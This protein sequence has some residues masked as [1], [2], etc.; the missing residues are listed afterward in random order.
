MEQLVEAGLSVL[1]ASRAP[2]VGGG[3]LAEDPKQAA[4]VN[5]TDTGFTPE[6]SNEPVDSSEPR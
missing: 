6:A 3:R 2:A 1:L 5:E 4:D